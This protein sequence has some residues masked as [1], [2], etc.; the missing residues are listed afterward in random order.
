MS[1]VIRQ[2]NMIAEA[3]GAVLSPCG[4]WRYTLHRG[5][6][7]DRP[8]VMFIGLNPSTADA[9][10]NDPTV[11]RCIR[12]A[13]DWGYGG[14]WMMNLFAFRSTD[15]AGLLTADDPVG[16]ACDYTLRIVAESAGIIVAAWGAHRLATERGKSVCQLLN[17][18]V[19]CLERTKDGSP[20]HPLY[21]RSDRKPILYWSPAT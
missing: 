18:E 2:R 10:K 5:W 15:P 7:W 4:V 8:W 12:F 13:Q 9:S 17:R 14:M 21:V 19:H 1:D 16:P 11:R 3:A 20:R 6:L